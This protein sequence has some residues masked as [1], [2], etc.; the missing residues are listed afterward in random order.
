M[1]FIPI[2]F[3]FMAADTLFEQLWQFSLRIQKQFG[4]I[5]C[6]LY[7]QHQILKAQIRGKGR[8]STKKK[9]PVA[10]FSL[11]KFRI[12][13]EVTFAMFCP[14]NHVSSHFFVH[15]TYS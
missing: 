7:L 9:N 14:S 11:L 12:W 8:N 13:I 1:N 15:F 6:I 5:Y 10:S 4:K 3:A 2:F